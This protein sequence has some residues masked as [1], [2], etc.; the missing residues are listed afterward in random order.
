MAKFFLDT[1]YVIALEAADDQYHALALKHWQELIKT[2][3][4]LVTTS[5]VFAEIVTFFN[6]R[7]QHPKAVEI[8]QRL[9]KSPS[10]QMIQVESNLFE[11]GWQLFQQYDDKTYSLTDCVSFVLMKHLKINTALTFDK[12]FAQAGFTK[13]PKLT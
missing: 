4:H 12:H 1:S 11:E 9:L 7:Y 10:I 6:S 8:G 3:L 2:P 5:Y 13:F